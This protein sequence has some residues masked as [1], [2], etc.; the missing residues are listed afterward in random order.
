MATKFQNQLSNMT[1]TQFVGYIYDRFDTS[2]HH[3]GHFTKLK[4]IGPMEE[5]MATF[6]QLDFRTEGM[7]HVFFM[8]FFIIGLKD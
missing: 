6:K 2:T 5:F 3:L 7:T 4:Q 8:E 1:W